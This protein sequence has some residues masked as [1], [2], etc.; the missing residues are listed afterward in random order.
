MVTAFP[1][2]LQLTWRLTLVCCTD[3][4]LPFDTPINGKIQVD[5]L[6]WIITNKEKTIR[7]SNDNIVIQ[8]CYF[9]IIVQ[10]SIKV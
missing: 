3:H 9:Y 5:V 2:L 7:I 4:C 8:H 6:F 10:D 1:L